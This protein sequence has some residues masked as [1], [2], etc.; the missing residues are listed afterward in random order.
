MGRKEFILTLLNENKVVLQ[1]LGIR[2]IGI[3]GSVVRDEDT[4]ESD[5]DILVEF[6]REH[7]KFNKFSKLCDFLEIHIGKK[8]DLVTMDGLSPHFGKKILKEVQY[9]NINT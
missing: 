4:K 2:S 8:Y 7:R 9:V 6:E 5:Y 3:F 1:N